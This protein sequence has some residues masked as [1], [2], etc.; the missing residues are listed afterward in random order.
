M[1]EIAAKL[2]VTSV[3]AVDVPSKTSGSLGFFRAPSRLALPVRAAEKVVVAAT[4]I[5][6]GGS[7]VDVVS[8]GLL[9]SVEASDAWL[10]ALEHL[11]RTHIDQWRPPEALWDGP[12]EVLL[13]EVLEVI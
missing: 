8:S 9:P 4:V 5:R 2:G 6:P 11:V 3:V 13:P 12:A 1:N 10:T 7:S